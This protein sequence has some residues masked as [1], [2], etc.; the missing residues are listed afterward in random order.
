[1]RENKHELR[2]PTH[3]QLP[4]ACRFLKLLYYLIYLEKST[5]EHAGVWFTCAWIS[6]IYRIDDVN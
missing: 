2:R 5:L 4:L 3:I 1:M 6:D